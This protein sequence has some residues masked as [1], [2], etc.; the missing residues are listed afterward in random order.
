MRP[1]LDVLREDVYHS[2]LD[3]GRLHSCQILLVHRM[4]HLK[5]ARA[6]PI[7]R[8]PRLVLI[9]LALPGMSKGLARLGSGLDSVI[10]CI[11]QQQQREF[12]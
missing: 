5:K 2:I 6:L 4:A 7:C 11:S 10:L 1:L 8:G 9:M 3:I 12:R